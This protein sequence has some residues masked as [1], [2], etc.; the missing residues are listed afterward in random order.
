M[1]IRYGLLVFPLMLMACT[2]TVE[3]SSTITAPTVMTDLP[4]AP[5]ATRTDLTPVF[6]PTE[7]LLIPESL[8]RLLEDTEEMQAQRARLVDR[9]VGNSVYSAYAVNSRPSD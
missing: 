2:S 7:Q 3:I 9:A 8:D 4:Q 1:N 6:Q 5:G